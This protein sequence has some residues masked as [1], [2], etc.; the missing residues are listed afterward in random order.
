[1]GRSPQIRPRQG[2]GRAN[3]RRI[4][5]SSILPR[6]CGGRVP[7]PCPRFGVLL[8][9]WQCCACHGVVTPSGRNETP[10]WGELG[11]G[12]V[13]AAAEQAA[14][15]RD[16]EIERDEQQV[17]Q[18][19]GA[20]RCAFADGVCAVA[21]DGHRGEGVLLK[22]DAAFFAGAAMALLVLA[23]GAQVAQRGMAARAEPRGFLRIGA[24]LWAFHTPILSRARG[25]G[26]ARRLRCGLSVT[27][28]AGTAR[29][30][31][32]RGRQQRHTRYTARRASPFAHAQW[33]CARCSCIVIPR[34]G[35]TRNLLLPD[36]QRE[37]QKQVPRCARDDT[38]RGMRGAGAKRKSR[39]LTTI[40]KVR[41]WVRD[42]K[43]ILC[44]AGA[45]AREPPRAARIGIRARPMALRT[46]LLHC[47]SEERGGDR[48]G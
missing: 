28:F 19:R 47:H 21:R 7:L 37:R 27:L 34:S 31:G 39:S 14:N 22:I 4:P 10:R 8:Q 6:A 44:D 36:C 11:A 5:A 32:S 38:N 9:E 43:I 20:P 17:Q 23:R 33:L 48:A 24:A 1:M 41:G 3:L 18:Q 46:L 42:D 25:A 15:E 13:A 40:R 30:P 29:A 35:A 16:A 26:A 12:V 2:A 45:K